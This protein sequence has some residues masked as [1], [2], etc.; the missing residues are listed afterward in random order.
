[1]SNDTK[2]TLFGFLA[3]LLLIVALVVQKHFGIV[4]PEEL[5]LGLLFVCLTGLGYY[6][7]KSDKNITGK[8]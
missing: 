2:T 4:I 1:M 7:N 5:I 8:S 3:G 6:T